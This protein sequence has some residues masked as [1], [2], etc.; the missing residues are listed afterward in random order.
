VLTNEFVSAWVR[1]TFT[2]FDCA[3]RN[4]ADYASRSHRGLGATTGDDVGR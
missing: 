4:P 2:L 1:P 3:L